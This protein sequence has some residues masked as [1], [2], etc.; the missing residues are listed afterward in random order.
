MKKNKKKVEFS[1]RKVR[2][3]ERDK[4]RENERELGELRKFVA[5]GVVV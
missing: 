3:D 2:E 1:L 5:R 4:Q